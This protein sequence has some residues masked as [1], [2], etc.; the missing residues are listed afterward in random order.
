MNQKNLEAVDWRMVP[1]P[2]DDGS[3]N[4]L[5]GLSM[6]SVALPSTGGGQVNL[7]HLRGWSVLYFYPMT[8]RPDVPLPDGWDDIPGARGC[9]PQSCAF[10]DLSQEL[11][12]KGVSAVFGISTQNTEYQ[13]EAADR[14]HLPFALL[15]DAE[16]ELTTSLCLPTM[17]VDGKLLIKRLTLVLHGTQVKRLFFPVFPPDRNAAD[18]LKFMKSGQP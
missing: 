2:I 6:P 16:L 18:V 14:L 11:A 12:D 1:A 13:S 15:S 4:H 17:K 7:G 9:T 3:A 8:G 5:E 10:R